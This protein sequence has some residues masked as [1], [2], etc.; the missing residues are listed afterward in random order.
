MHADSSQSVSAPT[1]K[2][3]FK[4][5]GMTLH[6]SF[7]LRPNQSKQLGDGKG[8]LDEGPLNSLRKILN[9]VDLFIIDEISMVS[10]RQLYEIDQRLRNI[11]NPAEE[12]GG[13]SIL[14]VGHFGQLP[15]V[16]GDYVFAPPKHLHMGPISGNTL[17]KKFDYFK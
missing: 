14:V 12:F 6:A 15:P 16:G 5:F 10:S 7:R 4:V 9:N 3:A 2:A 13:K 1:G 8:H 17:W 11:F